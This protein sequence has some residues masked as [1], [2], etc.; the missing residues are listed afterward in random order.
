[1][2]KQRFEVL[3]RQHFFLYKFLRKYL[4]IFSRIKPL[5]SEFEILKKISTVSDFIALDVGSNDGSS[6]IS[7]R[8]YSKNSN[9][10]SFDPIQKPTLKLRQN[11]R[12]FS[13]GLSD[14]EE[15]SNFFV[16]V[17]KGLKLTQYASISKEQAFL[18]LSTDAKVQS[19]F[20]EF[21]AE[22][23]KLQTLDSFGA[24]PYFLKIDVEGFEYQV[25]AGGKRTIELYRPL[26]L[27]EIQNSRAFNEISKFLAELRYSA[28][29]SSRSIK[30]LKNTTEWISG[31]RNYVF[32]P[33]ENGPGWKW[34]NQ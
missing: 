31:I 20:L 26:I 1:M 9:I 4:L 30:Y 19:E 2:L 32:I 24:K 25:L 8:K 12:Y 6:I 23:R 28:Y 29:C 7:I 17:Y 14:V 27:I 33:T 5:E 15:T 10:W 11:E 22:V 13:C 16:P 34:K 21:V 3:V 18:Q